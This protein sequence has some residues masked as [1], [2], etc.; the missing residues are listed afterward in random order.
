MTD[1]PWK[2]WEGKIIP[3]PVVPW[4]PTPKIKSPRDK[5]WDELS[6]TRLEICKYCNHMYTRQIKN[7]DTLDRS[8][9]YVTVKLCK[10]APADSAY[11]DL[12]AQARWA[13]KTACPKGYWQDTQTINDIEKRL[14]E[15]DQQEADARKQ[16]EEARQ[17]LAA[18]RQSRC[19]M[20][21]ETP[22][23]C[24]SY[25]AN[26]AD[27]I[28]R[29]R[30]AASKNPILQNKDGNSGAFFDKEAQCPLNYWIE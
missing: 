24:P 16:E 26:N 2:T 19:A 22:E 3:T 29:C 9:E 5:L 18:S 21:G 14:D 1:E 6:Q 12:D 11:R 28:L 4:A 7:L 10:L 23:A 30:Q 27:G 25:S 13:Y 17:K 8:T 15:L 20:P